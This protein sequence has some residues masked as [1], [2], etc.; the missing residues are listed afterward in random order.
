LKSSEQISG[1]KELERSYSPRHIA[2]EWKV[3][4]TV[5]Q[6]LN[7]RLD[8]SKRGNIS[9]FAK[10]GCID[11]VTALKLK[12][13]NLLSLKRDSVRKDLRKFKV[14]HL[15]E[16]LGWFGYPPLESLDETEKSKL[17]LRRQED[18]I[19]VAE[20]S[21]F[22]AGQNSW[23]CFYCNE[24]DAFAYHSSSFREKV[25]DGR[26]KF[27]LFKEME[28]LETI[29][30]D[31]VSG[32]NRKNV[33]SLFYISSN[34]EKAFG[35]IS[36]KPEEGFE[37]PCRIC[38]Q[39]LEKNA[40]EL[41]MPV[42]EVLSLIEYK[43]QLTQAK[44][45]AS[46][47]INQATISRIKNFKQKFIAPELVRKI[48]RFLFL[49]DLNYHPK[50]EQKE[51]VKKKLEMNGFIVSGKTFYEKPEISTSC[52]YISANKNANENRH[53]LHC[54]FT[55]QSSLNDIKVAC[56][57]NCHNINDIY[58][59]I[60]IS[61]TLNAT[62]LYVAQNYM[63]KHSLVCIDLR[64]GQIESCALPFAVSPLLVRSLEDKDLFNELDQA[65]INTD[66]ESGDI[67]AF[68]LLERPNKT[69]QLIEN[70]HT[71]DWED[72]YFK[73]LEFNNRGTRSLSEFFNRDNY[74]E[75][76]ESAQ[77]FY[78]NDNFS[79]FLFAHPF[80]ELAVNFRKEIRKSTGTALRAL[81][82]LQ[83]MYNI[84][85]VVI[86]LTT[87]PEQRYFKDM[88][89][90]RSKFTAYGTAIESNGF[91]ANDAV[92]IEEELDELLGLDLLSDDD[93]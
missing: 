6:W 80:H 83:K 73:E 39:C 84:D 48:Y 31:E 16:E 12:D 34:N 10:S 26:D 32:K 20:T 28:G 11:Y 79:I 54:D 51:L 49:G 2:E 82:E 25:G 44:L 52:G 72:E 14:A 43:F 93:L 50:L 67:E 90:L 21:A 78:L 30:L 13:T 36:H 40:A 55:V 1:N 64:Y 76:F 69:L 53:N 66:I 35:A 63:L 45:A 77:S 37:V 71:M 85:E 22:R 89:Q 68:Q 65:I 7:R 91:I 57:L 38:Y 92:S 41:S 81:Y 87:D 17:Q 18:F 88:E 15:D 86:N 42:S 8:F 75:S 62:H 23:F 61:K 29:K 19:S 46:L 4:D 33:I 3:G 47:G 24:P 70:W 60:A 56:F 27:T 58:I 74:F 9:K 5:K 59:Y